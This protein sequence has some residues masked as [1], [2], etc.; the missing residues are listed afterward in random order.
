MYSC[1]TGSKLNLFPGVK[2]L[3]LIFVKY[4]LIYLSIALT[5]CLYHP[6]VAISIPYLSHC[7]WFLALFCIDSS[8]FLLNFILVEVIKFL[9]SFLLYLYLGVKT[10]LHT[11]NTTCK[12]WNNKHISSILCFLYIDKSFLQTLCCLQSLACLIK[13]VNS[14]DHSTKYLTTNTCK[15][16]TS[17]HT[18][19]S[20]AT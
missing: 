6:L 10:F 8:Y 9:Y 15:T 2:I 11:F 20:K 18:K 17:K 13:I 16:C 19:G 14:L 12:T 1:F 7:L 3:I 4:L 5:T